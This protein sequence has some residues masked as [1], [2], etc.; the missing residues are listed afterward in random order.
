MNRGARALL[1]ALANGVPKS[2]PFLNLWATAENQA[3]KIAG[4]IALG[5]GLLIKRE[6]VQ[7]AWDFVYQCTA[8][9][10][11]TLEKSE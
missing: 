6:Y 3:I 11:K 1:A 8:A 4:L 9:T 7:W 5:D 10:N 2:G